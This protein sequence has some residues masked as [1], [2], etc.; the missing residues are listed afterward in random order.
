[1]AVPAEREQLLDFC[2]V[3][4]KRDAIR[5]CNGPLPANHVTSFDCSSSATGLESA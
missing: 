3:G 5:G 2:R 4:L 1:M